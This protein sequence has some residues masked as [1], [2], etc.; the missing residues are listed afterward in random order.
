MMNTTNLI[1]N[2]DINLNSDFDNKLNINDYN[3]YLECDEDLINK[4][5]EKY[6]K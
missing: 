1:N 6:N 5:L 4:L 2:L 3:N